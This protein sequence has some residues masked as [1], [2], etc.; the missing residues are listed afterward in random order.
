MNDNKLIE[1]WRKENAQMRSDSIKMI[2]Y[3]IVVCEAL[4]V[5]RGPLSGIV[6]IKLARQWQHLLTQYG[7]PCY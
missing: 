5:Q 4:A 7:E 2:K 6:Y 1:Q 3:N